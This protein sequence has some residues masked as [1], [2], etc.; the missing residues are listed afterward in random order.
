MDHI[1]IASTLDT[2]K[3]S[4]LYVT[5]KFLGRPWRHKG[6]TWKRLKVQGLAPKLHSSS[7]MNCALLVAYSIVVIHTAIVGRLSVLRRSE[8]LSKDHGVDFR[9]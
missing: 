2:C 3:N 8:I 6:Q 7:D 5:R 9:L 4:A 1:A